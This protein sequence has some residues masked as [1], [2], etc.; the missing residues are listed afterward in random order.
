[1]EEEKL[2][3][4]NYEHSYEL[5]MN[6]HTYNFINSIHVKIKNAKILYMNINM[7][8]KACDNYSYEQKKQ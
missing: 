4:T 3:N 6:I 8:L 2:L 7:I 1:M 5:I